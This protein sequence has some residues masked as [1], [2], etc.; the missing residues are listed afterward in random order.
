M[1]TRYEQ[2]NERT[3]EAYIKSAIDKSVLK[4]RIKNAA[5]NEKEQSFSA[6]ADA[7]LYILTAEEAEPMQ[8][9]LDCEVFNVHGIK[10]PVHGQS[11]GQALYH[12]LPHDREIILLHFF[13]GLDDLK[14][15]KVIHSSR[16]TVQRRRT[17]AMNK[18]RI[19]LE[20]SV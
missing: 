1:D 8:D 6:L 18:L 2:F 7:V 9:E 20:D 10:I 17:A 15:A 11:L 14:I 19:F 13:L 4:A 5:R 12:L 16:S 3:F